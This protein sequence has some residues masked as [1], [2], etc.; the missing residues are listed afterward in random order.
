HDRAHHLAPVATGARARRDAPLQSLGY[1][2]VLTT[3]IE[4]GAQIQADQIYDYHL[5]IGPKKANESDKKSIRISGETLLQLDSECLHG[6]LRLREARNLC[7]SILSRY[8]GNKQL[9]S[10]ELYNAFINAGT[11]A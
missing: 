8:L 2:L 1:G 4:T 9:K 11:S 3:D 10:R 7:R 5:D 6:K